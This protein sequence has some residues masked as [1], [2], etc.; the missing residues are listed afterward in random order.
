M[1]GI[2]GT[3]PNPT[4]QVERVESPVMESSLPYPIKSTARGHEGKLAPLSLECPFQRKVQPRWTCRG[5][6]IRSN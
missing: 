5:A 2:E 3:T 4:M 6:T 1:A